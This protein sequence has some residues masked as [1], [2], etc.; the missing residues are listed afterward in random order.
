MAAEAPSGSPPPGNKDDG[1]AVLGI[2]IGESA[3]ASAVGLATATSGP[4]ASLAASASRER[5]D[6]NRQR[7]WPRRP[8]PPLLVG[9]VALSGPSEDD[10]G[11][12]LVIL[13]ANED[14]GSR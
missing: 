2:L 12:G 9:G 10:V 1:A 6:I 4:V 3:S 11:D 14:T 5:K 13:P 7:G 8:P